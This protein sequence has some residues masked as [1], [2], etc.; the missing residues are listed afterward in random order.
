MLTNTKHSE[1]RP[2]TL[3]G[4]HLSLFARSI[5]LLLLP[6]LLILILGFGHHLSEPTPATSGLGS[7]VRA[8]A[9]EEKIDATHVAYTRNTIMEARI[10]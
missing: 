8:N 9:R 6:G 4:F 5:F 2:G 1:T 7:V 3:L 10:S